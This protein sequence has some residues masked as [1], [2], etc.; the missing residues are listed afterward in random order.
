MALL[1]LGTGCLLDAAI[2]PYQGKDTSEIAMLRHLLSSLAAKQESILPRQISLT[3][4]LLVI[5]FGV[6]ACKCSAKVKRETLQKVKFGW[7]FEVT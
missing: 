4:M 6:C 7:G 3:P 1:H 5:S 2:G